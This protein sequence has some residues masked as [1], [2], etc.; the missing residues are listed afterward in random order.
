MIG[1]GGNDTVKGGGGNDT[2]YGSSGDDQL[3]G[4]AGNDHLIGGTG[5]NV[6]EGGDGAD[7]LDGTDG[8]GVAD[9]RNS[10]TA[11]TVRLDNSGNAGHE[12]VGDTYVNIVGAF[13][14][15]F[16]DTIVGDNGGNWIVAAAATNGVRRGRQRHPLRL[17][18]Q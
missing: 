1:D 16:G 13:G 14:S 8:C 12:A 15:N 17:G 4:G 9:Y 10:D 2:L 18:G 6:L 7:V 11:V 5:N 3:V